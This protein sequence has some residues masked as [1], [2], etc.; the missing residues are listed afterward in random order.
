MRAGWKNHGAAVWLVALMLFHDSR[1]HTRTGDQVR[2]IDAAGAIEL[3]E[4][5]GAGKA[6]RFE[7]LRELERRYA[8]PPGG[9]VGRDRHVLA[10]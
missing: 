10:A 9:I 3:H 2:L 4:R 1:R 5:G 7:A 8:C 6:I